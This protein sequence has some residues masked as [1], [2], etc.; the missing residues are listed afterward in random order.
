MQE[1]RIETIGRRQYLIC[2]YDKRK[3]NYNEVIEAAMKKHGI[4]KPITTFVYP[5]KGK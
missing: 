1:S 3:K 5:E 4:K 2:Y